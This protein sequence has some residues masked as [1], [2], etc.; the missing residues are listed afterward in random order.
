MNLGLG[1]QQTMF[2]LNHGDPSHSIEFNDSQ[3]TYAD[4]VRGLS[5]GPSALK[6]WTQRPSNCGPNCVLFLSSDLNYFS[7]NKLSLSTF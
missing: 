6:R 2:Y 5:H 1:F 4:F 7:I 3:R